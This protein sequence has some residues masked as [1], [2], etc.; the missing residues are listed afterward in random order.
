MG[1]TQVIGFT[2]FGWD[3]IQILFSY[4]RFVKGCDI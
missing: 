1:R 4:R 3:I 2:P